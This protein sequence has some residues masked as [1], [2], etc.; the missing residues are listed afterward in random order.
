M[1]VYV[2][3]RSVCVCVLVCVCVSALARARADKAVLMWQATALVQARSFSLSLA[4]LKRES[5]P[6]RPPQDLK[7]FQ[8]A[9]RIRLAC[10]ARERERERERERVT[11]GEANAPRESSREYGARIYMHTEIA[12]MQARTHTYTYYIHF[13]HRT[14]IPPSHEFI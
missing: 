3:G 8:G 13:P 6:F 9:F 1:C 10:H 12:C 11:E 5:R 4:L 7:A 14:R 2:W